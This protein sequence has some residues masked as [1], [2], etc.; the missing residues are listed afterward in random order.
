MIIGIGTDIIE[1]PRIAQSL[2]KYGN[3]FINR[4]FTPTEIDYCESFKVNKELHYAVRFAAK[5]S[6]SKAIGTGITSG[7][8]LKEVGIINDE[9]GKPEIQLFG[10]LA[11]K[12]GKYKIQVSLSHTDTN[13][14]A[15]IVIEE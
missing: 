14:L 6:F 5:E 10:G 13:A 15:F 2:E 1:I 9:A 8:K 3:R 11:E 4:I 7:F 12:Y